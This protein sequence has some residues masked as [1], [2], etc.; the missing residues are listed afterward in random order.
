[1]GA[2]LFGRVFMKV[3]QGVVERAACGVGDFAE[4]RLVVRG[5]AAAVGEGE[6]RDGHQYDGR[7]ARGYPRFEYRA[8]DEPLR[9]VGR[10]VVGHGLEVRHLLREVAQAQL[11]RDLPEPGEGQSPIRVL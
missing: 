6:E 7:A 5:V 4:A 3:V 10:A 2:A 8:H 11:T 9:V 1:E